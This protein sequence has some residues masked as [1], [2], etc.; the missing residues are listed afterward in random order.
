MFNLKMAL[1]ISMTLFLQDQLALA[2]EVLYELL[3]LCFFLR[4]SIKEV[5]INGEISFIYINVHLRERKKKLQIIV[6]KPKF[7]PFL[8]ITFA[9]DM[10]PANRT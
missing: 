9:V 1:L 6:N 5:M 10:L 3:G 2:Q 7:P 8:L 4:R